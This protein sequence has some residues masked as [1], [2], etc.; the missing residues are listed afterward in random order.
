MISEFEKQEI[1]ATLIKSKM[2]RLYKEAMDRE[3][4]SESNQR[5][6]E[7]M[8]KEA[9][10]YAVEYI[11]K[12][13]D[14]LV[15]F[16][17][18]GKQHSY[19]VLNIMGKLIDN[20]IVE[21]SEKNNNYIS[22]YEAA[23]LILSA[24]FHD[25]GMSI[26]DGA[27]VEEEKGFNDY[28][29]ENLYN[30]REIIQ[31]YIRNKHHERARIFIRDYIM[32]M[33]PQFYKAN[34]S[35]VNAITIENNLFYVCE[36][37]NMGKEGFDDLKATEYYDMKFCGVILRLADI[38]DLDNSRAPIDRMKAIKFEDTEEDE[39]SWY[40][41]LKHRESEGIVIDEANK[42][43]L[44][45]T[46]SQ[47]IVYRK[48][49]NMLEIIRMEL[50]FCNDMLQ[51]MSLSH[52][53]IKL[54]TILKDEIR[55]NGFEVKEY[56]YSLQKKDIEN[57]FMK[58]NLYMD[59][60]V[61]IRELLQNAIDASY[62]YKKIRSKELKEEEVNFDEIS[63]KPIE[64]YV[65]NDEEEKTSFL[66]K[67]YGIGMNEDIIE[68]YF[69]KVGNSFYSSTLFERTGVE[70][71]AIS[72]FGIGFLSTFMVTDNITVV[73]RH[74]TKNSKD[75]LWKLTLEKNGNEY[76]VCK[77]ENIDGVIKY[78]ES[79]IMLS[80]MYST[81]VDI[82]GTMIYFQIKKD[83]LDTSEEHFVHKLD[84]YMC[85]PP[86]E[87]C[88]KIFETEKKYGKELEG[89]FI[90]NS[91]KKLDKDKILRNEVDSYR[92]DEDII[93]E[94]CPIELK[95]ENNDD[96]IFGM[97]NI[98]AVYNS[99]PRQKQYNPIYDFNYD[100]DAILIKIK[101]HQDLIR[102]LKLN[103][104]Y[105]Q[106]GISN[107]IKVYFNGICHLEEQN[108]RQKTSALGASP[109][110]SGY[111]LLE[112]KYKP[113]VNVA[114]DGAGYLDLHT[115][116]EVNYLYW[117][118]IFQHVNNDPYKKNAF[119]SLKQPEIMIGLQD[120]IY[121]GDE[122]NAQI[123]DISKWNELPIIQ[124]KN[125]FCSVCEILDYLKNEQVEEIE[126]FE[127]ISLN[128]VKDFRKL[129][130]C[131]LLQNNFTVV[132]KVQ[133]MQEKVFIKNKRDD[134]IGNMELPPL[135][136]M[137]YDNMEILKYNNYPLNNAYWFSKW[138][139]GNNSNEEM[140]KDMVSLIRIFQLDWLT[141]SYKKDIY[142]ERINNILRK[143]SDEVL[144]CREILTYG[145]NDEDVRKWLEID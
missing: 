51:E 66:I 72:H 70:Y 68:N 96:K 23:I 61:F 75:D 37:H 142:V 131:Y 19:N 125:G 52:K 21:E 30:N 134:G 90:K 8:I 69:L 78:G 81:G 26:L 97:L 118:K 136:F 103:L 87:V 114:R 27:N 29:Q 12:I 33:N 56:A 59:K 28:K 88:C 55:T 25:I 107:K 77:N 31:K 124:T 85:M 145:R 109:Y 16:T 104:N 7:A 49:H 94:S 1:N 130:I 86:V 60:M 54:P 95:Y 139:V 110:M 44:Q 106:K 140:K 120:M 141:N 50:A 43:I 93:F 135:F 80:N 67:D 32:K 40:E 5:K 89:P 115:M 38:L 34:T 24:F 73:T 98:M 99:A 53:K 11:E 63:I 41:W 83:I 100:E 102:D 138:L 58:E 14:V 82:H 119:F 45:A 6:N 113:N 18:H 111:I 62:F 92:V 128:Q 65:W 15:K 20:S 10:Y 35:T 2:W 91:V 71:E 13:Q 127:D 108:V 117:Q 123:Q 129:I 84:Q 47:P 144:N 22:S 79:K 74:Y 39:Y 132:L 64:I 76:I 57:L 42:L 143:Y 101:H 116:L 121:Y 126:V 17:C 3:G 137:E 105:K 133:E 4:I 48:L 36:S 46:V 122:L 112:G 9:I